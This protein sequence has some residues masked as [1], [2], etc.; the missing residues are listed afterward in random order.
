ME[1]DEFLSAEEGVFYDYALPPEVPPE[2]TSNVTNI[3]SELPL[4]ISS[5]IPQHLMGEGAE[6]TLSSIVTYLNSV[7]GVDI[8]LI[9]TTIVITLV[10]I[11]IIIVVTYLVAKAVNKVL[12]IH[13]PRLVH[14]DKVGFD[15]DQEK[16]LRTIIS[17]LLVAAVYILGFILVISQIPTL[18][19]VAVTLLAGA[20]V[21]G[22]AIGFA[23]QGSLANVISGVFLAVFHPFR[24]GDYIDFEGNYGQIEDLTLRHTVIRTW[25]GRRIM[26][27]NSNM[28]DQ[29]IINWTIRD[30][31]ITWT[32]NIGIAYTANIDKAREI[33]MEEARRHP[34][35]MKNREISVKVTELGDF[36]VNMR[37]Y[38][39]VMSRAVA[40]TTGYEIIEAVKK[41][42][43]RSGIEIPYPYR[44]LI[45]HQDLGD[46]VSQQSG[47]EKEMK[48]GFGVSDS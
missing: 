32:V 17:R 9:A 7:L 47:D 33:M 19:N 40:L 6:S 27:P 8:G 1:E 16:T 2:T 30:P 11:S 39:Q 3:S 36:A 14:A 24:V 22:L 43:D 45:I 31:E 38:F 12:N 46:Q 37:L 15:V 20:G 18:N 4:E 28:N 29:N 10:N 23:A 42:F 34:L 21:A 35:V 5:E 48:D 44:N 13:M 41:K 26:V 25:D